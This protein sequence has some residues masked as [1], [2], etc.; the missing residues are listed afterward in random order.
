MKSI[1]ET[2]GTVLEI[3]EKDVALQEAKSMAEITLGKRHEE[4]LGKIAELMVKFADR[5]IE[6]DC[7]AL[8]K[9]W[10]EKHW[11]RWVGLDSFLA[12]IDGDY[13]IVSLVLDC[14]DRVDRIQDINTH[15][16]FPADSVK[17]WKKI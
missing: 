3:L 4:F 2:T 13:H 1:T 8:S 10:D 11:S 6:V 12:L 14:R 15:E 17:A 5:W 9:E 7:E 16:Y